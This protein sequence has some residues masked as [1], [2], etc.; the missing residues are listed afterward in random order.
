MLAAGNGTP[1][2]CV[3]NLLSIVRGENPFERCKGMSAELSDAPLSQVMGEVVTE[4]AWN[5]KNYEPR[6]ET[7]DINLV[8]E[9][10]LRGRYRIGTG[11]IT[12]NG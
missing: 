6:A 9:D 2:Q 7:E 1:Q 12:G 5:V 11:I 10:V 3:F 8:M 4:A